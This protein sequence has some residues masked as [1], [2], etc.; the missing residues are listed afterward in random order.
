MFSS[1]FFTLVEELLQDIDNLR[2]SVS[3]THPEHSNSN[4]NDIGPLL[5][6]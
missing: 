3:H 6:H 2:D 5:T 4:R 1:Q